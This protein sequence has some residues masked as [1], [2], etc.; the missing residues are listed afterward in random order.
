MRI[1]ILETGRPPEELTGKHGS[2]PGMFV[3]LLAKEDPALEFTFYAAL[4]GEVPSDPHAC[5]AWLITGSRHGVYEKLP[6]MADLS[7][8]I[9]AA[10]AEKVPVVGI[11][12]G[13]QIMAEAL[14]GKVEKSNKGWGLGLH[15]YGLNA[16][17]PAW[18]SD[19]E[20]T[21]AIPAVHQDQVV[22]LPPGAKAVASSEFCENAA[23]AYDGPGFSVQGHPEFSEPYQRD[24]YVARKAILP[25][26]VVAK[27]VQ[28]F[29][30]QASDSR[31]VAQWIVA[32][33][34][35]AKL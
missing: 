9:R 21:F 17:R 12:F 34:K 8:L 5:D 30:Q 26:P 18:M 20:A 19:E 31:T 14:G 25:E 6:W 29:G 24:L 4:D 13:H 33:L 11:C 15:S 22:T 23:I 16:D 27:A 7:A 10:F 28:S 3:N 1:G 2:Y 32:F 35:S